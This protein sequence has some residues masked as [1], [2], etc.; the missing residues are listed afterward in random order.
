MDRIVVALSELVRRAPGP[1]VIGAVVVTVVLAALSTQVQVAMGNEGFAPDNPEL[2]ATEIISKRFSGSAEGVAQ[3]LVTGGEVISADGVAAVQAIRDAIQGSAAGAHLADRPDRP[4]VL[5][6]LDP[7]HQALAQQGVALETADDATVKATFTQA[8]EGLPPERLGLLTGLLPDGA[9]PAAAHADAG[10]L[11]VFLD[12]ESITPHGADGTEEFDALIEVQAGLAEAVR[13]ARLPAGMTAETFSFPL[14]FADTDAFEAELARLFASAFIIIL[15]ILGFVYWLRPGL[16][17]ATLGAGRRTAADVLLTM[18]TIVMAISWMNGI[19]VL[20]GP[21][22]AGVIGGLTEVSQ[23]VPVLLIGLGVDY[24][25][26]LTS[27]YREEVAGGASVPEGIGRAVTTVGVALVLATVTTAV[28]FLTNIIN[29]VPALRDFGILAAVGIVASFVLMLTFVPAVRLLLDRR[30]ESRARLPRQA[31][32]RTSERALP[33]IM[34]RTSVLAERAPVATL[35]ATVLL[36]GAL[37]VW[38]LTELETRFS[39]TDFVSDESP[40]VKTFDEIVERFGGGFGETT[41][42]LISGG[43]ATPQVHNGLVQAVDNLASVED[44]S[45]FGDRA[46]AE[47]PVSVLGLLLAPGP[48]GAPLA[49][50]VVEAAAAAGVAPDLTVPPDADVAA[51]YDALL[52][53]AP[54]EAAGVLGRDEAGTYDLARVSIQ[55]NAGESGA[56]ALMENLETAFA[57]V[58]AAGPDTVATSN[59]IINQVIVTALSDSQLSSMAVTLLAAMLLLAVTYWFRSRRPLLGILTVAPVVLVV[60][61]TFGMMAATGIPF[62]PVTATIAALAIGIGVP[63]TIHITNRYLEDRIIHAD[64]VQAIRS[65]VRHTGGALAGSAFTTCAGFGVLMTSSL[66]PFRQFGAVTVFAI[67]FALLAATLVLPSLLML[68]DRWH[69]RR[70]PPEQA[71][72]EEPVGV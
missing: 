4:A 63:Y 61:W 16:G 29:P 43:V 20:L 30:A 71:P 56:A 33:G 46:Q 70:T 60:L 55:T 50:P 58:E 45:T 47:S 9:D 39:I 26:H 13:A 34:A 17:L 18:A 68:W 67:G 44:V 2:R 69:R 52:A 27:R 14:L 41:D 32:G 22:Y 48:D 37:G 7:V 12:T 8:L 23:I 11:L 5:S 31:L 35:L 64:P 62:G 72:L 51:L 24:A 38:G 54:A 19:A 25:I 65:T 66:T 1:V 42:V 6:W 36:G 3:V 59:E 53:A 15:V 49:P 28:G 40:V 57:P 21:D 10:L